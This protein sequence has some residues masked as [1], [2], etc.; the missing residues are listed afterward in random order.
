MTFVSGEGKSGDGKTRGMV[1]TFG[2]ERRVAEEKEES[3]KNVT[4][5]EI[6]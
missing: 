4:S 1:K 2:T 6:K 5:T 3:S